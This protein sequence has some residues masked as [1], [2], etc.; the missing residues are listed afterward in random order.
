[1]DGGKKSAGTCLGALDVDAE[2]LLCSPRG[3][4]G[5]GGRWV[6]YVVGRKKESGGERRRNNKEGRRTGGGWQA[7]S[8]VEDIWLAWGYLKM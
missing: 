1:M 5:I 4:A 6:G 3:W 2:R 7:R 8:R